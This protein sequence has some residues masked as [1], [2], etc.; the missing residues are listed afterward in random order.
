MLAANPFACDVTRHL[1]QLQ[2]D[3]QALLSRHRAITLDLFGRGS[4]SGHESSIRELP[5]CD[6]CRMK[7]ETMGYGD[8]GGMQAARGLA[9]GWKKGENSPCHPRSGVAVSR[10]FF[11]RE[12][13]LWHTQFSKPAGN[14]TE[15]RRVT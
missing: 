5:F 6:N 3:R 1:V 9:A 2:R 10:P 13:S 15:S 12:P 11:Q 14:N 8:W 7:G 4:R